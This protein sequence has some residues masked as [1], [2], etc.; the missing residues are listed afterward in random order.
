MRFNGTAIYVYNALA[1]TV[2]STDTATNITFTLDDVDHHYTHKP[3][4]G[5]AFDYKIPVYTKENLANMEHV[6]VIQANSLI[7]FDYAV[8]TFDDTLTS[9][10][11]SPT[12]SRKVS[13]SMLSRP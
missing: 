9:S 2:A 8:Y 5:T 1:N 10:A 4:N 11:T 12:S 3:T 7:L 6:L 13:A